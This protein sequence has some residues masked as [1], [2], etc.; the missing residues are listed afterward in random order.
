M[1]ELPEPEFI[2][3]SFDNN[4]MFRAFY[5]VDLKKEEKE[6][7]RGEDL[8]VDLEKIPDNLPELQQQLDIA[9]VLDKITADNIEVTK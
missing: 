2:D 7:E 8:Q 4:R 9:S 1:Q 5:L 6:I 3:I